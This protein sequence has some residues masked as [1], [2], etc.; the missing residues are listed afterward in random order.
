MP[1]AEAECLELRMHIQARPYGR[2][3]GGHSWNNNAGSMPPMPG[4]VPMGLPMMPPMP[5]VMGMGAGLPMGFMPPGFLPPG[6]GSDYACLWNLHHHTRASQSMCMIVWSPAR[7][8]E[9]KRVA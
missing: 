3:P 2:P 4:Q 7:D 9:L 1:V 8:M 6:E 5:G